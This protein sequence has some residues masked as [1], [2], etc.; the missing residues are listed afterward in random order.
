MAAKNR[1]VSRP[2]V[3]S[4][5]SNRQV[6]WIAAAFLVSGVPALIYQTVWQR[7]LVLHSGV[8][9]TSVAIIVSMYMIGLGIGSLGAANLSKRVS[10]NNALY[11]FAGLELFVA[12]YALAS[13]ALLYDVLYVRFGGLYANGWLAALLHFAAAHLCDGGDIAIH[14]ARLRARASHRFQ[15]H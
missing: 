11:Y 9:T 13:P 10:P 14:D 8:G 3:A 15:A 12:M 6:Y 1:R 5:L 2:T 4:R 7:L